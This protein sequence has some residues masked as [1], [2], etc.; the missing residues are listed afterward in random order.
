MM[1]SSPAKPLIIMSNSAK[2]M[3]YWISAW[4]P[5]ALG[6]AVIAVE[7]QEFMGSDHTSSLFRPLYQAIFGHVSDARWEI[8][9]HHIRKCGHFTGYG[10]IGL[11]WLHAWWKTLPH[12]NFFRDATLALL[13]TAAIASCDELHQRFLPN[14]TGTP[15]DV[16][17]DCSGAIVLQLLVYLYLRIFQPRKLRPDA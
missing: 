12:S 8:L 1:S 10:L 15:V 11:A 9:H 4:G 17:I 5:V 16:M 13:G 7:S 6:V 3:W 2:G 14:R